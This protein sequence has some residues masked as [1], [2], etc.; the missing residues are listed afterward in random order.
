[1]AKKS[2]FDSPILLWKDE[3][4]VHRKTLHHFYN[5]RKCRSCV[6]EMGIF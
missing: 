2:A 5:R 3:G 4:F 1:M 6:Y